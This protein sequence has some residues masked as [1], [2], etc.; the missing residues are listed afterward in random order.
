MTD[1]AG[2]MVLEKQRSTFLQGGT[3]KEYS[4]KMAEAADEYTKNFLQERYK[5]VLESLK[6][7]DGAIEKMVESLYETETITGEEVVDIIK[8]FEEENG[9]KSRLTIHIEDD[10]DIKEAK[11]KK[12]QKKENPTT[13]EDDKE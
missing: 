9:M 11:Q 3:Q 2:L 12:K 8:D 1:V 4:S 13:K 5:N 7:Y 6:S 10:D